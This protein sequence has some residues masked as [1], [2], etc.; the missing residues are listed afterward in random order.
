MIEPVGKAKVGDDDVA[1]LV[2][3][4]VLELEVAVD[5][6]L[7]VEIVD[8]GDELRKELLRVSLL[9]IAIGEDVVEQLAACRSVRARDKYCGSLDV[10][11]PP[12]NSSTIPIYFS[13]SMTSN[14][15][16]MLGCLSVYAVSPTRRRVDSLSTRRSPAPPCWRGFRHPDSLS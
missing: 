1:V 15:R 13:V 10:D 3:E 9:Q 14:M 6:V 2:E 5:N 7:L 8:A 16:T 12:A 4:E 11:V